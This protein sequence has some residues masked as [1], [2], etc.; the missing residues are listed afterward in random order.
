[1]KII[2][3]DNLRLSKLKLKKK[4]K[5]KVFDQNVSEGKKVQQ[6]LRFMS[7]ETFAEFRLR[8]SILLKALSWILFYISII[9]LSFYSI[10]FLSIWIF[11][12][13]IEC[14]LFSTF[15]TSVP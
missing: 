5:K 4:D 3:T 14:Y 10:N 12:V 15:W 2:K 8:G 7:Y 11:V 13:F 9:H 6:K 1:M